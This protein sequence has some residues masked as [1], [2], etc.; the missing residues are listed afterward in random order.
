MTTTT[1]DLD[2]D[3]ITRHHH[4][5]TIAR[6]GADARFEKLIKFMRLQI[7]ITSSFLDMVH[8]FQHVDGDY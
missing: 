6:N 3:W 1:A 8:E 4:R 2:L 5:Q 7:E